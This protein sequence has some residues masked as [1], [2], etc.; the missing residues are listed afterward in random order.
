MV[1]ITATDIN[2]LTGP[3][4]V[5]Y[6]VAALLCPWIPALLAFRARRETGY[7]TLWDLASGTRVVIKPTGT[8]R[9]T[10]ARAWQPEKTG[11][12]VES[13]GPYQIVEELVPGK[14]IVATDTVLRRPVWL[15]RRTSTDLSPARRNVGRPGR[16]RWLQKVKTDETVW[17]AFEAQ[18]GESFCRLIDAETKIPWKKMRHWLHD[19]ATELWAAEGDQTLPTELSFANIWITGQGQAVL[20]DEPWPDTSFPLERFSVVKLDGQ[21]RF[22]SAIAV[23]VESTSLPIHARPVL[24]NLR[25]GKFVKLSFLTGTLRGLLERP[26]DISKGIRAGS[27]FMMPFWVWIMFFVGAYQGAEWLWRFTGD[28][29]WSFALI[30]AMMVLTANALIQILELPFCSTTSYHIFRLAVI[31]A[32]GERAGIS[33]LFRRWAITW[34]PLL[35]PMSL[36]VPAVLNDASTFALVSAFLWLF[37]WI[38]AA[39]FAMTN[40]NRGLHDRLAG[41]WVVRM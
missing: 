35:L 30:T 12:G 34:L 17:D 9:P 25:D 1:T 27:M 2:F 18:Q 26:A 4:I 40:P 10:L 33:T 24:A 20:L 16:L 28:S 13:I 29:V 31:N 22:L 39:F 11:E 23:Y 38:G 41:T 19:V 5:V 37:L 32:R 8:T 36:M 3:E 15:L 7:A 6:V 14:W 21:Q